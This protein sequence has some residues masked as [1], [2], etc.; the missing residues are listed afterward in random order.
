MSGRPDQRALGQLPRKS[1][2]KGG[3][4]FEIHNDDE[5]IDH[6]NDDEEDDEVEHLVV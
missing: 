3:G 1:I 5:D 4:R 6:D 2:A